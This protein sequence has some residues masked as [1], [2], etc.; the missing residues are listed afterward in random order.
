[1]ETFEWAGGDGVVGSLGKRERERE[2]RK[3]AKP[4]GRRRREDAYALPEARALSSL[5][6]TTGL[7]AF[8][9]TVPVPT[10]IARVQKRNNSVDVSCECIYAAS[11][12]LSMVL[13]SPPI[14]AIPGRISK[15]PPARL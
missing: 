15:S 6:S 2:R 1:M 9:F 14:A 11:L 5:N 4:D 13:T 8:T 12:P 3:V 10:H 7:V